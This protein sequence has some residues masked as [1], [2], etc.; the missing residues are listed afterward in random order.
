MS[1]RLWTQTYIHHHNE[2]ELTD[3][4]HSS[5]YNV[6]AVVAASP[7]LFVHLLSSSAVFKVQELQRTTKHKNCTRIVRHSQCKCILNILKKNYKESVNTF[8]V[9][10]SS[11]YARAMDYLYIY[12]KTMLYVLS[13][14][15]LA[16]RAHI[17]SIV[18]CHKD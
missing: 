13:L 9:Q 15:L 3:T 2:V 6:H 17:T 8:N 5:V 18:A 12:T 16:S 10:A 11:K 14:S 1:R 7:S 4:T